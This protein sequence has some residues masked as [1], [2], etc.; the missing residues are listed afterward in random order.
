MA[1]DSSSPGGIAPPC[2]KPYAFGLYSEMFLMRN[3]VP[4]IVL[5]LI[6]VPLAHVL[7]GEAAPSFD[8]AS[9]SAFERA[10]T[11]LP[12]DFNGDQVPDMVVVNKSS[13][14]FTQ[15]AVHL[16]SGVGDGSFSAG[17]R[18][19]D[20]VSDFAPGVGISADFNQDAVL[21]LLTDTTVPDNT[22][23]RI[24]LNSPDTPGTFIQE[25]ALPFGFSYTVGDFNGDPFPDLAFLTNTFVDNPDPQADEL[26]GT[27]EVYL[28]LGTVEGAWQG[29][30]SPTSF[31]STLDPGPANARAGF[32]L[33]AGD[34][35]GDGDT[36][37]A[38]DTV[39]LVNDGSGVFSRA[40]LTNEALSEDPLLLADLDLDGRDELVQGGITGENELALRDADIALYRWDSV[41]LEWDSLGEPVSAGQAAAFDLKPVA[42]DLSGD[43]V[44]DLVIGAGSHLLFLCGETGVD[45]SPEGEGNPSL[46]YRVTV[47]NIEYLDPEETTP[48]IAYS[49]RPA[50]V[51]LDGDQDLD[52]L[53]PKGGT[54]VITFDEV[55]VELVTY[56]RGEI[57]VLVY[58]DRMGDGIFDLQYFDD[59]LGRMDNGL[60]GIP[61]QLAGEGVEE[62]ATTAFIDFNENESIEAATE[63]GVVR[64]P[65]LL[66]GAYTLSWE[67]PNSN[68]LNS[69]GFENSTFEFNLLPG[70]VA[71]VLIGFREDPGGAT[72]TPEADFGDLPEAGTSFGTVPD[73]SIGEVV[74]PAHINNSPETQLWLGENVDY[75]DAL[76]RP[77]TPDAQADDLAEMD[78]ENGVQ[79]TRPFLRGAGNT[80]RLLNAG[81]PGFANLFVDA[82]G[83]RAF[84]EEEWVAKNT[85][86]SESG[87]TDLPF[88]LPGSGNLPESVYLRVRV[89]PFPIFKES[90]I[91]FGG[92]IEDYRLGGL[93]FGDAPDGYPVRL[94]DDGA[95]HALVSNLV[96]GSHVSAEADGEA[97]ASALGDV[98][99][100]RTEEDGIR[101]MTDVEAGTTAR[102]QVTSTG[103]GV[104]SA[105]IDFN[106]DGDWDDSGDQILADAPL[107]G[108]LAETLLDF[109]VPSDAL[110]GIT[111]ARF[112]LSTERALGP[113]GPALDGEVEDYQLQVF[114]SGA[115]PLNTLLAGDRMLEDTWTVSEWFGVFLR[116]PGGWIFHEHLGF[117]YLANAG[118]AGVFIYVPGLGWNFTN[119]DIFPY[120]HS[121]RENSPVF[122]NE[123]R[124]LPNRW[125]YFFDASPAGW[126]NFPEE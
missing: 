70:E 103:E 71:D 55:D 12:G 110:S 51:D 87:N 126:R 108:E 65:D 50:L 17:V 38:G 8:S 107:S 94:A 27:V 14:Q 60:N 44:P 5:A 46:T 22:G 64:F 18:I 32:S 84:G 43:G 31:D 119:Q 59:I 35:D 37:L 1:G 28:N 81:E 69:V 116:F 109:N 73:S 97:Q 80:L 96:L 40:L 6:F 62:T 123:E 4:L 39:T 26:V 10:D 124:L 79:F 104:L 13:T 112:R 33:V 49:G 117:V 82:D 30:G 120:L 63:V 76:N 125:F 115:S 11:V 54:D 111:Y 83:D 101:F 72:P 105:W 121:Y 99:L 58:F 41:N 66:L 95:T 42:G 25:L 98:D 48:V 74:G 67:V 56:A 68:Y 88:T 118:N 93:D 24:F 34:I 89:S 90:D 20:G 100:N 114:T 19:L 57:R 21:D 45:G 77:L 53:S 16:F 47:V 61:V 52:M 23:T 106:Q 2:F 122:L 91:V 78:D 29:F 15:G 86:L 3:R 7:R 36:D 113:G 92:E 9:V 85:P 75:G 102:I